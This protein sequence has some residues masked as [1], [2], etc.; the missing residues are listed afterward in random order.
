MLETRLHVYI[1]RGRK[2]EKRE[3]VFLWECVCCRETLWSFLSLLITLR[4]H[5]TR[6][7][8]AQCSSASGAGILIDVKPTKY[9]VHWWVP[10]RE[11]VRKMASTP[12]GHSQ[13]RRPKHVQFLSWNSAHMKI[14]CWLDN[15]CVEWKKVIVHFHQL[16]RFYCL[17]ITLSVAVLW[18]N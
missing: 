8:S 4:D 12:Q 17:F 16:W 14:P 1:L 9:S 3:S 15:V 18:Q 5:T 2:K 13:A 6:C 11:R 7:D 10:C